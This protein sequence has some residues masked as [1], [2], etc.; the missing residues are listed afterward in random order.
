VTPEDG[1]NPGVAQAEAWLDGLAGRGGATAPAQEGARLRA[2]LKPGGE[3]TSAVPAPP[4]QDVVAAAH[5]RAALPGGVPVRPPRKA[6]QGKRVAAAALAMVAMSLTLGVWV[7]SSRDKAADA[8][9]RG[10]PSANGA[11][12]RVENPQRAARELAKQLEAAGGRVALTANGDGSV[13][14]LHCDAPNCP[15]VSGLLAP[16]D[17]AVDANGQLEL[18][19]VPPR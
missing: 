2:A 10:A 7:L 16:L 15:R 13:L 3:E 12:W 18:Q 14:I 9:M 4:W 6:A 5:Q 19:I 8:R 1:K 17:L 11:V